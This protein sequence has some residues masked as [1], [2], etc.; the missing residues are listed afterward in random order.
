MEIIKHHLRGWVIQDTQR[1]W[2]NNPTVLQMY[3]TT[4]LKEVAGKDINLS[5]SG[6]Q[7]SLQNHTIQKCYSSY[8]DSHEYAAAAK[9]LQP[10]RTLCDPVDG[11][12]PGS[13]VPGILQ[14]RTLEWLA[15][16]FSV[17]WVYR[18]TIGILLYIYIRIEQL[19]KWMVYGRSHFQCWAWELYGQARER[20]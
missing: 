6:N 4:S 16:A 20:G 17:T 18:L 11:S 13:A 7:W 12:P 3:E 15:I 9:S 14:A 8:A 10:C 5:S 19:S 2:Q 1:M